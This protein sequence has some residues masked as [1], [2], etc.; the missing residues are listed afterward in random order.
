MKAKQII[1]K[2][3][4]NW[5]AKVVCF[6]MAIFFYFFYQVSTLDHRSFTVP[7]AIT[8]KAGMVPASTYPAHVKITVRAHP[9]DLASIH[10]SDLTA[11]LDLNTVSKEG[12]V[13]L[14]VLVKMASPLMLIDPFEVRVSPESVSMIVEEQISGYAPV[15]ALIEGTPV[16]GYECGTIAV[17]PAQVRISGPRSM[18]ENC[19][20]LQTSP[21]SVENEGA[22]RIERVAAVE[23]NGAFLSFDDVK[24]VVVSVDIVPQQT[25]KK[26]E[27]QTVRL[28][29]LLNTLDVAGT[30]PKTDL[31]LSGDVLNLD[32][33]TPGA[34]VVSADCSHIQTPGTYML[35]LIYAVPESLQ[36]TEDNPKSITV[37]IATRHDSS[38][39]PVDTNTEVQ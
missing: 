15:T 23:N 12:H 19:K 5:P 39:K 17:Q 1:E 26:Y 10:E 18:V 28:I 37:Q 3:T 22:G 36:V 29:H 31:V 13:K 33:Y 24:D 30:V 8:A 9:Q 14:P 21:V 27:S 6:I 7:L 35:P 11:Y 2:L 32:S 25:T 20:R 34:F 16:H 4:E 38:D